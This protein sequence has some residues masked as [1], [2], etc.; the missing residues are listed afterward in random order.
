LQTEVVVRSPLS[1]SIHP[2]KLTVDL[3]KNAEFTCTASGEPLPSSIVWLKDGT[4][5]R[6]GS[7]AGR[8]RFLSQNRIIISGVVRED[9]GIY[10][11]VVKNDYETGQQAAQLRLGGKFTI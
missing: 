4:I 5:L 3:G 11:C 1:V 10:Q 9:Q 7:S 2:E 6:T 8:V